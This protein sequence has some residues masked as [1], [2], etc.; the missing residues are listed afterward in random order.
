MSF[1]RGRTTRPLPAGQDSI[2]RLRAPL[3]AA[4]A[5][6]RAASA[7]RVIDFSPQWPEI[8]HSRA[9]RGK[10]RWRA[11]LSQPSDTSGRGATR[12]APFGE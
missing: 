11:R 6:D 10:T 3:F 7:D 2:R 1:L 9:L 12:P 5:R 8:E 4:A